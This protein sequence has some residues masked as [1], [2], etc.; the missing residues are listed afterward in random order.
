MTNFIKASAFTLGFVAAFGASTAMA[1]NVDIGTMSQGTLSYSTGAAIAQALQQAA[2]INA[3]VQP[4][5][6]ETTIMP[7]VNSG[8][9]TL[10]IA[11]IGEVANA[12]GGKG[13]FEGRPQENMV[14]LAALVPLTVGIF[15]R[16][17][18]DIETISDLEGRR[19]TVEFSAM[20]VI[21]DILLAS[22]AS[23]GLTVEQVESVA[24]PNVARGADDFIA[25]RADAFFFGIGAAKVLE[26]DASVGGLRMLPLSSDA[27]AVA[28]MSA[29]FPDGYLTELQPGANMPGFEAPIQVM[30]YDNILLI[31]ADAPDELAATIAKSI[32]ESKAALAA[33][34][35]P[36]NGLVV[37]DLYKDIGIAYHPGAIAYYEEAGL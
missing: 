17:D 12:V 18:S 33:S 14:A 3:R 22:L 10:G 36:F 20:G 6:G 35:P 30:T 24:V 11:S 26:A 21:N 9:L 2:G 1:Q 23:E 19:L 8:E 37:E 25:G 27:E 5:S 16:A 15:A 34:F 7:L 28:R 13:V 29:V 32:A 31:S 4:N